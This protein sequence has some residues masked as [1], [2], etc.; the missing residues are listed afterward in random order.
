VPGKR[1]FSDKAD[2]F[3]T[4]SLIFR[5]VKSSLTIP[6]INDRLTPSLR[7]GTFLLFHLGLNNFLCLGQS[8]HA[9]RLW[10]A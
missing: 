10:D 6:W 9:P 3:N 7:D 4:F 8:S 5:Y 2:F 1:K